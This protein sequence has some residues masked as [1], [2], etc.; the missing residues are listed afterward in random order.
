MTR[1][2]MEE[3]TE[4][5]SKVYSCDDHGEKIVTDATGYWDEVDSEIRRTTPD[6]PRLPENQAVQ[7]SVLNAKG[8]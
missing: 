7:S 6:D 1:S 4:Q 5:S 3:E 2:S 8:K